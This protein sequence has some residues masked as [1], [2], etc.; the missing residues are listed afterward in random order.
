MAQVINGRFDAGKGYF[1]WAESIYYDDIDHT[2]TVHH[3][4][5]LRFFE[6]AREHMLGQRFLPSLLQSQNTIIVAV[7]TDQKHADFSTATLG[8][9]L[10]IRTKVQTQG[11]YR[12]IFNHE[13]WRTSGAAKEKDIEECAPLL[14]VSGSVEMVCLDAEKL[15]VVPLPEEMTKEMMIMAQDAE[16]IGQQAKPKRVLRKPSRDASKSVDWLGV[17]NDFDTDFTK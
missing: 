1:S 10:E 11:E 2:N 15:S 4:Y 8:D 16:Q 9:K 6:H 7:K 12:I 14:V 13:A 5:Y 17:V 3:A